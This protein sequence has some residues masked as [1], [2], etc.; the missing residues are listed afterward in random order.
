MR[1]AVDIAAWLRKLGLER[2][3]QAF[4][5]N[6]VDSRSLPHLTADDL[7]ELGVTAIGH[8]RLLLQ[9]IADLK[10]SG[11]LAV[12]P[13]TERITS[14][15][16]V[17][18][19]AQAERR[20]LTV[21]FIDLVGSTE[22]SARLDPEDMGQVIRAY[23]GCCNQ[24]VERW[25]GH[26]AKYMGDGVLVYFGYPQAH[27]DDAE[28]AVRAG[29]DLTGAVGRLA[30]PSGETLVARVGI[31]TGLVMVGDL[32]GG[33]SADKDA[34]VGETPNL[35]ARLQ[36]VAQP[37]NVVI[38]PI[39][40]RLLG[41]VFEMEDLGP[42]ELKGFAQ[43]VPVSRV[44][45][46]SPTESRFR[47][48]RGVHSTPLVGRERELEA[49]E[50][51]RREA[52]ASRGQIVAAVGEPGVGKSRLFDA[53]LRS[54]AFIGWRLLSC[55]C[56]SYGAATPWLPVIELVK[57]YFRIDDRDDQ[58]RMSAKVDQGLQ[59]LGAVRRANRALLSLLHLP[60]EDAHWETLNPPQRR[61]RILDTVKALLLLESEREP[62]VLMVE[63]LH[64]AD[65]ETVALLDSLI[66]SL[67]THRILVLVNYRP[68]FQ[69]FWGGLTYYRQLRIDPL[70]TE[71]AEQ[72][73]AALLGR[74]SDLGD[75][76][77]TLIKRT[78][79]NPLFLEEAVRDLVETGALV[80]RSGD[81]R[82]ARRGGEIRL[83]DTVQ[84]IIAA[85]IDRLP[86][87]ARRL[88]Q[89]AAVIGHDIP[90]RVLESVA[91]LSAEEVGHHLGALRAS[92]L[93]YETG[94]VPDVE[95]TFKHAL[96]RD[97]AYASLLRETRRM[98]HRRV[99]ETIESVYP[100]RLAELAE[101]LADH[102]EKGEVWAKAARYALD[103]AEK[104]KS[105]FAYRI[106]MRFA[107]RACSS[108]AQDPSLEQ[109]LIWAKVLLGDVA[110]LIDDLDLAN[111]SYD[112]A[113][114]K[115]QD[116]TE[117][118]WIVNKRHEPHSVIRDAARITYYEHGGGNDT[119]LFV[120][121]VSYGLATW[122]PVVERLCQEF[123]IITVDPRGTGRSDPIIRPYTS[124]DH[125]LD[126][127][128]VVETAADRPVIGVGISR[129]GTMVT[130]AAAAVPTL[131]KMLV[132]VGTP[133]GA[134]APGDVLFEKLAAERRFLQQNQFE[135]ALRSLA[136]SIISEPGTEDLVEQRVQAYLRLP[137]ETVLSFYDPQPQADSALI[138]LLNQLR[139]PV[140]VMHGT[141]D[142]RV[143]FEDARLLAQRVAGAQLYP[144]DGRCHFFTATATAE[145][146]DLL[147]HFVLTGSVPSSTQAAQVLSR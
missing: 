72:L 55:A 88:L 94:L 64:W 76:R 113:L 85:R 69:H 45:R 32:L 63:D 144:F 128:T 98:L 39:T 120:S 59:A 77:R 40:R 127:A 8:R 60:N 43:P 132:L 29:L 131:F 109:E 46:E 142:Q 115:S 13:A 81:Y 106:A 141:G 107:E 56:L 123:R 105:H 25:G 102:F 87:Q 11:T 97:V 3:V 116:L 54:D 26:V 135:R 22:L 147:R 73:L 5:D 143:P 136:S 101:T 41:R 7:K 2:Y 104:A 129:G 34:V 20:Q 27:E 31:A 100:E 42:Q 138:P 21:M 134:G 10:Q 37:G 82:L 68:E 58:N 75:L 126:L 38:A 57:R 108:A 6:E 114:A 112:E 49:L 133:A 51:A 4:Q 110:S 122:Q 95:Y 103:A 80:G 79:G 35:A 125:G 78:E 71:G 90:L 111:R 9:A 47:A 84:A 52:G 50:E 89:R 28:R 61:R 121:P 1:E 23:Q 140:L 130:H 74:G 14:S 44:I 12:E 139:L 62:F 124:K 30:V 24:V 17:G 118:R 119:L 19:A 96:T 83:P 146:C 117:R 16:T 86:Q 15:D 92:E 66:D 99:G 53:F 137:T 33:G 65:G 93:L 91:D 48:Q 18:G 36:T 70:G 67:P 145:F